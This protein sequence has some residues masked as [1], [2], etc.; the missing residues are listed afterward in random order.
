[1]SRRRIQSSDDSL[2]MLLDTMCNAFGGIVLIAI[3]VALLV[4]KPGEPIKGIRPDAHLLDEKQKELRELQPRSEE[5]ESELEKMG[6]VIELIRKRD[7]T[8]AAVQKKQEQGAL[9]MDELSNRL[10]KELAKKEAEE[11]KAGELSKEI[12]SLEVQKKDL[13]RQ[14]SE[15][16]NQTKDL[17]SSRQRE[18]SPPKLHG[19]EG[20]Q[21]VFIV[22]YNE[23]FPVKD[24]K[25]AS[26]GKVVDG[27]R[28]SVALKWAGDQAIAIQGKGLKLEGDQEKILQLFKGMSLY[29]RRQASSPQEKLYA[30][31]LTYG[32]SFD[33]LESFRK[34]VVNVGGV[35][36]GWE[37]H[38]DESVIKFGPGG[39]K[40]EKG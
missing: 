31:F 3:M 27:G 33:S 4:E 22:R 30:F 29:N 25:F 19:N 2:D 8:L 7:E 38:T 37:P 11:S 18:L 28:N 24:Y 6:E 17:I 26:D 35:E 14:I 36:D 5:A 20:G 15:L 13:V 32:D 21:V 12:A 16:D 9:T 39:R 1:M 10:N 40:G 23:I 34:L